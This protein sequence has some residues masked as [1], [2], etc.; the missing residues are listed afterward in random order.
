MAI[1]EK[2]KSLPHKP[3][4]YLMKDAR[5]RVIYVGKAQSLRDRVRSYFSSASGL[6]PRSQLLISKIEDFEYIVTDSPI[7]ALILEANL[8]KLH[9]PRYNVRLKDD[10]KYP[11]IKV[12]IGEDYPRAF[13]TRNLR[14][15]GSILFGPYTNAKAMR[16]ALRTAKKIFPVRSCRGRLPPKVCL[17]YHIQRC[18]GPCEGGISKEDYRKMV[19]ELCRFLSGKSRRVEKEL[20]ARM[21]NL[22]DGLRFEE[23]ARVRDQLIAV[24]EIVRK[25]RV[26]FANPADRDIIGLA[27]AGRT[28][29]VVVLQ[30]RDGKLI[31]REHYFLEGLKRIEDAEV[32]STFVGQYYRN[33]YFVPTEIVLSS[34]IGE[35][36]SFE[37]WLSARKGKTVRFQFP[38]KG[39]KARILS[40]ARENARLILEEELLKKKERI[41]ASILEL[42]RALSLQNPPRRMEAFDISDIF[43]E[44]AVGSSVLFKDGR[45]KKSGYRKYRIK[46][47]SG[48]DD[49]AMIGEVVGR[50]FRRLVEEKKKLPDLV[51]IDGGIGQLTKAIEAM[52][53][54][55]VELPT[56]GLAKRLDELYLPDGRVLSLPKT[57]P[58]LR[59]LQ[60]VR[61][62]AHRFAIGYHRQLRRKG[63]RMSILD[64]IPGIGEV[65]KREL[66]KAFG[67]VE[68][69][70]NASME[71]IA[72]AK[73]IGPVF[74]RRIWEF[75]QTESG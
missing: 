46:T 4:V 39:E 61:D 15:D 64:E 41:P 63:A 8:I 38:K 68:G 36:A 35:R 29:C 23:A 21:R 74:A 24:R 19:E 58:A 18:Y 49:F 22:A 10:K 7:E 5:G 27:R 56:F 50:R 47:V 69:L 60:R 34:E 44:Y 1:S 20:E 45:S 16:K 40:M 3:G 17:D 6:G 65:K 26:V 28:S 31:G 75:L 57:S 52:G 2:L 55:G 32:L 33:S 37:S 43:G 30:I 42:Q 9:L 48:I 25:Q 51:L 72:R 12:T 54:A 14:K 62:E 11:Y 53:D 13:P 59:L 70:M 66:L 73:G 71:E 67:S